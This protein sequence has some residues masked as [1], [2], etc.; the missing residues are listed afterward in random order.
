VQSKKHDS[1]MTSTDDGIQIEVSD[2]QE[3]NADLPRIDTLHPPSNAILKRSL[4]SEKDDSYMT[5]IDEG[6]KIDRILNS[7][8]ASSPMTARPARWM[9]DPATQR[10]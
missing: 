2:P 6:I 9:T 5:S 3:K 1:E 8:G 7:I 4:Q 10:R